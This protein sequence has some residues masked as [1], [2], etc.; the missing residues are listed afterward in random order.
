MNGVEVNK[1]SVQLLIGINTVNWKT[2]RSRYPGGGVL[3]IFWV[4]RHVIGKGVDFNDFGI[5]NS[6]N[7]RNFGI[8]NGIDFAILVKG[9]VLI[10]MI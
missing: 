3:N 10:F 5:R 2:I 4:Q 9:M 1:F 8:R 6:I 7:F